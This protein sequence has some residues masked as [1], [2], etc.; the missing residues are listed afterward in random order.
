MS[1]RRRA[2]AAAAA[3]RR[4]HISRHTREDLEKKTEIQTEMQT[5][6]NNGVSK[7]SRCSIQRRFPC[8]CFS[9]N[10]WGRGIVTTVTT[11]TLQRQTVRGGQTQKQHSREQRQFLEQRPQRAASWE[12][13]GLSPRQFSVHFAQHFAQLFAPP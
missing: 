13:P 2:A 3:R 6:S 7:E 11:G 4:L 10:C 5:E 1:R 12:G 8:M 9:S